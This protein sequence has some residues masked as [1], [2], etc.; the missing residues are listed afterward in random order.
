MG[1]AKLR[2]LPC[3]PPSRAVSTLCILVV[4]LY[5]RVDNVREMLLLLL[6]WDSMTLRAAMMEHSGMCTTRVCN[7]PDISNH[8]QL[9]YLPLYFVRAG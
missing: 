7:S 6:Q 5:A 9:I 8:A 4:V 1:G 3:L 2:E